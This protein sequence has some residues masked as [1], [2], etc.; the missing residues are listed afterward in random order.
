MVGET[1][2]LISW[3]LQQSNKNKIN[4]I[5]WRNFLKKNVMENSLIR[6]KPYERQ[7]ITF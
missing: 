2:L 6:I 5:F 4:Y 3:S 7:S 1:Q